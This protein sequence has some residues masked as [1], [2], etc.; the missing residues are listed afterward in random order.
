M[1]LRFLHAEKV[2]QIKMPVEGAGGDLAAV[3][4]A[5][6]GRGRGAEGKRGS[7]RT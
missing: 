7:V 4:T 2:R 5:V 3:L 1:L 6:M